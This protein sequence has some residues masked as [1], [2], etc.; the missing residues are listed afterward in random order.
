MPALCRELAPFSPRG[1]TVLLEDVAAIEMA[2]LIEMIVDGGVSRSKLLQG[3][4]V[5]E[6]RH[7]PLL[8]AGTTDVSFRLDY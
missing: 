2:F 6:F 1:G 5:S 4:D 7:R 3:L 8:V